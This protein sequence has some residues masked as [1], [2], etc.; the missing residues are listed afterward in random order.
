M[1][2]I[3][4]ETDGRSVVNEVDQVENETTPGEGG[5]A[6][7][8]G[9]DPGDKLT[10]SEVQRRSILDDVAGLL[11]IS[12]SM[13][14]IPSISSKEVYGVVLDA[15]SDGQV[16][17][18]KD[19]MFF[20]VRTCVP[21]G[22]VRDGLLKSWSA[23]DRVFHNVLGQT[24][25]ELKTQG[26][27]LGTKDG[28]RVVAGEHGDSLEQVDDPVKQVI[29]VAGSVVE[30]VK[31]NPFDTSV[32]SGKAVVPRPN[33][34]VR[35][36]A[37]PASVSPGQVKSRDRVRALAEVYTHE[38]EVN[39]MLDLVSD[40]FPVDGT[41]RQLELITK[42]FLEPACGNGNFLEEILH[43][44][45]EWMPATDEIWDSHHLQ[46][47]TL[48]AL[49]SIY[50]IDIDQENVDESRERLRM[51]V[52]DH[53]TARSDIGEDAVDDDFDA[54]VREVLRTNIVRAN[55]LVE[56]EE[57]VWVDYKSL[58]GGRFQREFSRAA[59]HGEGGDV[60]MSDAE[61]F[62]YSDLMNQIDAGKMKFPPRRKGVQR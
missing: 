10:P 37:M 13:Q 22:P 31:V 23:C 19:L 52:W 6:L 60:L 61:P 29:E 35:P 2:S 55:T 7:D 5:A 46:Y 16:H 42:K 36:P 45:L 39:A 21:E 17:R 27:V 9:L 50:A 15:L 3:M 57:I 26:L 20:V 43:R 32:S 56:L 30:S 40:M 62:V 24:L 47:S 14:D 25:R 38:C 48:V 34:A 49:A 59:V 54:L 58:P 33:K 8:D 18:R 1:L 53:V 51:V 28:Y 41:A 44:K 4:S 11:G 12:V